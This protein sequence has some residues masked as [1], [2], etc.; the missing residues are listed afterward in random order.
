MKKFKNNKGIALVT[1]LIAITF[2]GILA[3]SL[4]YLTYMNYMAKSM[5]Y[6]STDNF[7]TTEYGLADLSTALQNKAANCAS[8]SAALDA[9]K[10]SEVNTVYGNLKILTTY[11]GVDCYDCRALEALITEASREAKIEVQTTYDKDGSDGNF[12]WPQTKN[13]ELGSNYITFKGVRIISTTKKGYVSSIHTD[14]T[15]MFGSSKGE[16][17]VNDFSII[18]DSPVIV[19]MK[20][21]VIGGNVFVGNGGDS[22]KNALQLQNVAIC[23][24]LSPHG[25]IN[26]DV[27]V[28]GGCTLII[29]GSVTVYGKIT[30]KSSGSLITTGDVQTTNG[31]VIESGGIARGKILSSKPGNPNLPDT[32]IDADGDGTV[33]NKLAAKL[34]SSTFVKCNQNH[35]WIPFEL[36]DLHDCLGDGKGTFK[37]TGSAVSLS[38]GC[39]NDINPG[40]KKDTLLLNAY[41]GRNPMCIRGSIPNS[42]I[43]SVYPIKFY[44][45][46]GSA[47]WG[48]AYLDCMDDA[49]YEYAKRILIGGSDANGRQ[50][51]TST[52]NNDNIN[53]APAD[54]VLGVTVTFPMTGTNIDK[55]EITAPSLESDGRTAYYDT[56][57]KSNYI[58]GGYFI[59]ENSSQ[60]ISDAFS[61]TQ[62]DISAKD[63]YVVYKNWE[64]E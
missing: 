30:V 25:I 48:S 13:Y 12:I 49:D 10:T 32:G 42:T 60:I 63:A 40:E 21:V 7:Y 4:M 55:E 56:T 29:S 31:I 43:L 17:D 57:T 64:K 62:G 34:L 3:T 39:S 59:A 38:I 33:D 18:T 1:V 5:R 20:N 35:T 61:A 50:L 24:L 19:D 22:T 36:S 53:F 8:V 44:D 11:N 37:P 58:P 51:K 27:E 6:S 16:M 28:Q 14:I 26:G 41:A 45:N 2:I 52:C 15:I 47:E 23:T 9:F 54:S 46:N